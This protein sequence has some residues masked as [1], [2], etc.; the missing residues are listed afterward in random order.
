MKAAP[1]SAGVNATEQATL[2][3]GVYVGAGLGSQFTGSSAT[4]IVRKY[5]PGRKF[6]RNGVIKYENN[7]ERQIFLSSREEIIPL[8]VP[9][10]CLPASEVGRERAR[11]W[12][13]NQARRR[14]FRPLT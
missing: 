6:G 2:Q 4:R 13:R 8:F 7:D 3:S 1:A 10:I 14:E 5:L 9:F 12:R 11:R